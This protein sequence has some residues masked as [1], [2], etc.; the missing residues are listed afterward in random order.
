MNRKITL[1]TIF[2]VAVL[3]ASLVIIIYNQNYIQKNE[4]PKATP[5]WIDY[6]YTSKI[7]AL[8]S[9][10]PSE[11]YFNVTQGS[12]LLINITFTS[13]T[14]QP[15]EI[16]IENL[17]LSTYSDKINPNVWSNT[18]Y[19]SLIQDNV[20]TY[21]YGPNSVI[22]QPY[23]ANSTILTVKFADNSPVGQYYL[24]SNLG[25]AIL[26]SAQSEANYYSGIGI[27]IIVLPKQG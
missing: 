3:L 25:R 9:E 16:P 17:T 18:G 13:I 15:I 11:T 2:I 27:E 19:T 1:I 12:T 8:N 23:T 5:D 14:N 10:V 20:F 26:L 21:S 22:V 24:E 6:V 7:S 4:P